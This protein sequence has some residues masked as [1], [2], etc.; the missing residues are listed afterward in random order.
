MILSGAPACVRAR[1]AHG[2]RAPALGQPALARVMSTRTAPPRKAQRKFGPR[3]PAGHSSRKP[4]RGGLPAP[5][6]SKHQE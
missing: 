6:S 5:V 1:A 4:S 2:P 3:G